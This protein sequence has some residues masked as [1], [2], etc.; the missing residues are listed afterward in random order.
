MPNVPVG[1]PMRCGVL[2]EIIES[3]SS[4]YEPGDLVVNLFVRPLSL[5]SSYCSKGKK[6]QPNPQGQI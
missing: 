3:A 4:S 2:A 5:A 1:S 6:D